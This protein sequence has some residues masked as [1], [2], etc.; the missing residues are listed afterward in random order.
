MHIY[1]K[2]IFFPILTIHTGAYYTL[3]MKQSTGSYG[4]IDTWLTWWRFFLSFFLW[5]GPECERCFSTQPVSWADII[6]SS[7]RRVTFYYIGVSGLGLVAVVPS[8]YRATKV[9]FFSLR[10]TRVWC[11]PCCYR[12]AYI[13]RWAV[14]TWFLLDPASTKSFKYTWL[15]TSLSRVRFVL[16]GYIKL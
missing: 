1:T 5:R 15:Y 12:H 7:C 8:Y 6:C 11:S 3:T 16:I 4:V 10:E 13:L 9:L 2:Y 14:I